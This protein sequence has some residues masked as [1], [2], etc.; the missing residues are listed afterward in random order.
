MCGYQLSIHLERT[1]LSSCLAFC[2]GDFVRKCSKSIDS[3]T[4]AAHEDMVLSISIDAI[5][6]QLITCGVDSYVRFWKFQS[7]EVTHELA[8]EWPITTTLMHK[9]WYGSSCKFD[10]F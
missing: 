10:Q 1:E 7:R 3:N 6:D 2:R 5:N 9:E 4:V 8:F